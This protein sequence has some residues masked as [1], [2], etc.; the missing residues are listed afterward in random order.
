MG[1]CQVMWAATHFLLGEMSGREEMKQ[2]FLR[3]GC[4]KKGE[5][6]RKQYLSLC[7]AGV[8]LAVDLLALQEETLALWAHWKW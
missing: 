7:E 2:Q 1:K 4:N 3:K 8:L 6:H 5:E